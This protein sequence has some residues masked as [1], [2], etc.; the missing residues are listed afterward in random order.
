MGIKH[1]LLNIGSLPSKVVLDDDLIS[2]HHIDVFFRTDTW[3]SRDEI[4]S[5]NESTPQ[6]Y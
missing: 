6:S 3:L 4:V 5:L 1:G 2:H